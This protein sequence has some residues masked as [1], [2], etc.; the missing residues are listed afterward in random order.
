MTCFEEEYTPLKDTRRFKRDAV[1]SM[2]KEKEWIPEIESCWELDFCIEK[3]ERDLISERV[4]FDSLEEFVYH[5]D[6]IFCC[7]WDTSIRDWFQW[8]NEQGEDE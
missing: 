6:W 1:L 8:R 2:M 4:K 5:V 3:A 7:E